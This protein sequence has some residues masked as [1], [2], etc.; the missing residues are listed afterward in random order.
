MGLLDR[1]FG[2]YARGGAAAT[3]QS[4]HATIDHFGQTMTTS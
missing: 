3:C 1:L 4:C 2:R